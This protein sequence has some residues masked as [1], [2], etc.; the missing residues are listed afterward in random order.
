MMST[1]CRVTTG[2]GE[3]R[4]DPNRTAL[5]R[6]ITSIWLKALWIVVARGRI[7]L[8]TRGFSEIQ[9]VDSI[10]IYQPV[11][12]A[13]VALSASLRITMHS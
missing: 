10:H 4:S 1:H 12:G 2:G 5:S 7:E 3:A 6:D 13:S 8:P 9:V 11:T